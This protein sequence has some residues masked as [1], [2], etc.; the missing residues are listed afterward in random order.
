MILS[1]YRATDDGHIFDK[2]NQCFI[3]E[4]KSNK[5]LQCQVYDDNGQVHVLGVH[6]VVAR[7]RCLDW[8]EGCIVHHK[9]GDCHNN[10]VNNLS[11]Y[12]RSY[13]SR[14]HI[15][16]SG[17]SK[18]LSDYVKEHGPANKGKTMSEEFK[19]K[20]SCSARRRGFNG[21]QYVDRNKNKR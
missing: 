13:H 19:H 9:D 11:C 15:I 17:S 5:Y 4:F 21:N 2:E 20:C 1:R 6:Q 12:S 14:Q 18:R 7:L 10:S 8:F 16:D 3:K